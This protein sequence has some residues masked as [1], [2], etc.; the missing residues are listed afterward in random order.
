MAIN[1]SGIVWNNIKAIVLTIVP[2]TN[3]LFNVDFT[4]SKFPAP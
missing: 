3:T 4:L 1:L 2:I